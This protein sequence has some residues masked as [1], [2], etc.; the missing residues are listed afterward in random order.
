MKILKSQHGY[1]ALISVIIVSISLLTLV[2]SVS[3]TGFYSRF[4]VLESEQKEISNYLAEAC[5]NTAI[6]KISQNETYTGAQTISVGAQ[7]CEI[8]SV[9]TGNIFVSNRLIKAQGVYEDAYTNI[10]VE[11]DP[12]DLPIID[13][14]SWTE[15]PSF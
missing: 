6:L 14:K 3:F 12:D 15:V 8:V 4:S 7:N 13:I 5:I 9:T 10:E 11:I 1:I 2:I